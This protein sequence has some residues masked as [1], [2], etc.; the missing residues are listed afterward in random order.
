MCWF[1]LSL[2]KL[3]PGF[4]H[5]LQLPPRTLVQ[6]TSLLA[7]LI[8]LAISLFLGTAQQTQFIAGLPQ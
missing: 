2:T 8:E 1:F 5:H 3:I 7:L 6:C 4:F